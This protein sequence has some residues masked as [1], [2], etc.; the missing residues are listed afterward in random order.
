MPKDSPAWKTSIVRKSKAH[1]AAC[2]DILPSRQE[3]VCILSIRISVKDQTLCNQTKVR[4][5]GCLK[6]HS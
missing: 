5:F 3:A 6:S 2:A 4:C 1:E